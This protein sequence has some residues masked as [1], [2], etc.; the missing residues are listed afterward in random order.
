MERK[1]YMQNWYIN[2]KNYILDLDGRKT[3]GGKLTEFEE[4]DLDKWIKKFRPTGTRWK[5]VRSGRPYDK[6]VRCNGLSIKRERILVS[7]C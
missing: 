2:K 7:F 4:Y 1:I 5:T 3:D 6:G